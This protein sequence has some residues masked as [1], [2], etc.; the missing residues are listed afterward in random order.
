MAAYRWMADSRDSYGAQRKAK[1]ENSMSLYRC[2]TIFNVRPC[3]HTFR[4]L[5]DHPVL[6]NMPQGS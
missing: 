4:P 5:S 1:M 3:L 2:H 6:S